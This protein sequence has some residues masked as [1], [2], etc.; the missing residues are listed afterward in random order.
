MPPKDSSPQ[1]VIINGVECEPYLTADHRVMPERGEELLIGLQI[2]MKATGVQKGFIGIENNK[3]DA[4][5]HLSNL[6][7][8]FV[9]IEICP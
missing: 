7:K 6:A 4:I 1:V 8:Q 3:K 5:Q 2:L 9:G